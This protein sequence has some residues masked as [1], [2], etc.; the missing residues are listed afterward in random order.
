MTV[1]QRTGPWPEDH[2]LRRGFIAFGLKPPQAGSGSTPSADAAETEDDPEGIRMELFRR[3]R[4]RA[5]WSNAVK[6]IVP[7][8]DKQAPADAPRR[9]PDPDSEE[10][11][12]DSDA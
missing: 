9:A 5:M 11:S 4:A 1:T 3:A 2:P 8:E 7:A 10:R 12:G 6:H